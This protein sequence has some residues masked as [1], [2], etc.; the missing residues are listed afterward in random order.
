MEEQQQQEE[1]ACTLL[2][3]VELAETDR[4][5]GLAD[6]PEPRLAAGRIG[7][8]PLEE[9]VEEVVEEVVDSAA[10]PI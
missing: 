6:I 4:V 7:G 1:E 2:P 3:S 9:P 8:V 10:E 5:S